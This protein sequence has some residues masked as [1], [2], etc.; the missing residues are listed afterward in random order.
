MNYSER[1][2]IVAQVLMG[3]RINEATQIEQFS[4][5]APHE[6]SFDDWLINKAIEQAKTIIKAVK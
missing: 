4:S 1:A 3:L 5:E 2:A 6:I